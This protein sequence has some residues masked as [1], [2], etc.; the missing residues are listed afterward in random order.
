M[1]K[2]SFYIGLNDKETKRQEI[3]TLDAFK[4]VENVFNTFCKYGATIR[5]CKGIYKHESG[6]KVIE[7][8][9]ES[10]TTE[11]LETQT[12]NDIV[13]V[14]KNT[15]NQESILVTQETVNVMFL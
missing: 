6:E 11:E 3:N 2:T 15:L 14:L 1:I 5:E 8:T 10:F 9:L 7:N 12:I 13:K 4:I